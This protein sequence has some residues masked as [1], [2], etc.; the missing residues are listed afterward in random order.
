MIPSRKHTTTPYTTLAV[1]GLAKT[2]SRISLVFHDFSP[3]WLVVVV[4]G[5]QL[6]VLQVQPTLCSPTSLPLYNIFDNLDKIK[7]WIL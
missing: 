3:G 2:T 1:L 7:S 4:V 5:Y 6:L